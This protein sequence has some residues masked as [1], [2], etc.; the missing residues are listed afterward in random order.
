MK[1]KQDTVCVGCILASRMPAL[2]GALLCQKHEEQNGK[3]ALENAPIIGS[4]MNTLEIKPSF[5]AQRS[6]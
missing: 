3:P 5:Q 6:Q 1:R 2:L 4:K